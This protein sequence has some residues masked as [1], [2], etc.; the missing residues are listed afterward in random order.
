MTITD[1]STVAATKSPIYNVLPLIDVSGTGQ[2]EPF[3]APGRIILKIDG[4]M[5]GGK[6]FIEELHDGDWITYPAHETEIAD[7]WQVNL[8]VNEICRIAYDGVG[9]ISIRPTPSWGKN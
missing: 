3:Y 8:T 9:T 1:Q 6:V 2:G 5:S 7:A 4:D